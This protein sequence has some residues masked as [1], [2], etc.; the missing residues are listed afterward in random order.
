MSAHSYWDELAVGYAMHALEPDDEQQFET[1]VAECRMCTAVLAEY[2]AVLAQLAYAAEPIIPPARV[3]AAIR[4]GLG[5]SEP[6]STPLPPTGR[7]P[8][9]RAARRGV[10]RPALGGL[11]TRG[12]WR[13]EVTARAS[14]TTG[15]LIAVSLAVVVGLAGWNVA[16]QTDHSTQTALPSKRDVVL[17]TI[18]QAGAQTLTLS[19]PATGKT[20]ALAVIRD[21]HLWLVLD[22]LPPNRRG[23]ETYV[24]WQRWTI[25]GPPLALRAFDAAGGSNAQVIDVGVLATD[26]SAISGFAI[27]REAGQRAPVS[28][29]GPPVA[30]GT[31]SRT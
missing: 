14:R 18:E 19:S 5:L 4:A 23:Q 2:D 21:Q 31:V 13:A 10:G 26:L 6:S 12:S 15:A 30:S 11:L 16:L 17:A 22:G 7:H 8:T 25:G 27:T 1:H 20:R 9:R 24:L 29:T 28:P 3:L